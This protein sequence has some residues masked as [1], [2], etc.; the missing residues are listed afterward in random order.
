MCPF[1]IIFWFVW[2]QKDHLFY[3]NMEN[4]G[5]LFFSYIER[6]EFSNGEHSGIVANIVDKLISI[7]GIVWKFYCFIY[8][9][10]IYVIW[11][12]DY[13]FWSVSW[14][15]LIEFSHYSSVFIWTFWMGASAIRQQT[16]PYEHRLFSWK[17][18]LASGKQA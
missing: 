11:Y 12:F 7:L 16:F 9:L 17:Q 14:I 5:K 4:S 15:F 6:F 18:I 8:R 10:T 2:W 1:K 13:T 3:C